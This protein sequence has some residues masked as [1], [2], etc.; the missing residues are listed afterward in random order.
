MPAGHA[1]Q[2]VKGN[3]M[4]KWLCWVSLGIAGLLLFLFLLDFILYMVGSS[5]MPFGGISPWVVDIIGC[6]ASGLLVYLA[7]DA[8]REIH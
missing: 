8:V 7:W 5:F 1:L 6:L 2:A 4:E 3:S